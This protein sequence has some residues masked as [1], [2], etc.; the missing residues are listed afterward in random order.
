MAVFI[1]VSLPMMQW[2]I[3]RLRVLLN[4]FLLPSF[5]HGPRRLARKKLPVSY[6]R[7]NYQL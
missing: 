7:S 2:S 5:S 4:S 1:N 6:P 3:D